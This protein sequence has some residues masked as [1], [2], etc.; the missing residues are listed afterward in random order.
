MVKTLIRSGANVE[1]RSSRGYPLHQGTA[2]HIASRAGHEHI[3]DALIRAGAN[4]NTRDDDGKT[5][6][7]WTSEE[8]TGHHLVVNAL[9]RGGANM[10]P[11]DR[12]GWTPLNLMIVFGHDAA[13]KSLIR[14][15]ANLNVRLEDNKRTPLLQALR[16][17]RYSIVKELLDNG[18][19]PNLKDSEGETPL[20]VASRFGVIPM[21]KELVIRGAN[22]SLKNNNGKTPAN[23]AKTNE[24]QN[25]IERWLPERRKRQ[26]LAIKALNNRFPP[27]ISRDSGLGYNSNMNNAPR[28]RQ[29]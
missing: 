24:I 3:V 28:K 12:N 2:L 8:D 29:R 16:M 14:A 7:H 15:G 11:K 17:R 5:P 21:V 10:N 18:A 13:A 6:L 20:H 25:V 9:I 26:T 4:V 23:V 27:N 19:N 1:S 22:P